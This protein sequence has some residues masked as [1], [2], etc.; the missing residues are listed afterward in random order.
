MNN[1]KAL[2]VG[3]A[4]KRLEK[5]DKDGFQVTWGL[6]SAFKKSDNWPWA[7][8]FY[9]EEFR[10]AGHVVSTRKDRSDVSLT[11]YTMP[12]N[13]SVEEHG[14]PTVSVLLIYT[15]NPLKE[16]AEESELFSKAWEQLSDCDESRHWICIAE[17][18]SE[19]WIKK[20]SK[21]D[22]QLF[23]RELGIDIN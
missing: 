21:G 12:S 6:E 10:L 18:P 8:V 11:S 5:F 3:E 1:N 14:V 22:D 9:R 4:I 20:A 2:T 7:I 17:S 13:H 15:K 23:L 16:L 19:E